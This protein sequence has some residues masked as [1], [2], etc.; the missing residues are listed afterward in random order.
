MTSETAEGFVIFR[1]SLYSRKRIIFH[2]FLHFLVPALV[3]FIF[4]RKSWQKAFI[5]MMLTMVIDIDHLLATPIYDPMRCSMGFHPLHTWPFV[6]LYSA[7]LLW[8]KTRIIGAGLIIHMVLDSI[9]CKINL[10]VWM[11]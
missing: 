4:F 10:G 8:P 2:I 6:C 5:I 3:A 11:M 1:D 7:L 9:D